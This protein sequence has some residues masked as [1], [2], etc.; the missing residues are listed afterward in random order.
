MIM[1]RGFL[2]FVLPL[3]AICLAWP[4]ASVGLP[5]LPSKDLPSTALSPTLQVKTPA[6]G[7]NWALGSKH[8]ITWTS[9]NVNGYLRIDLFR[10]LPSPHKVGTITGNVAVSNGKYTWD[11]GKYLGGA[12]TEHGKNY[13]IV[14]TTDNPSLT[15]S[16]PL[17]NLTTA[18]SQLNPPLLTGIKKLTLTYPRRGDAFHKGMRYTITWQSVNLNNTRLKLEL[19]DNDEV[20]LRQTIANNFENK[21]KMD[22]DVPKL[23]NKEGFYKIKLQTMDGAQK[24]I[25]GP[26][27]IS[28]GTALPPSLKV[29]NPI[30]GD[31]SFGDTIPV[32][33]TSTAACSGSGGPRDAAFKIELIKY[34]DRD[35][36]IAQDMLTD[37]GFSFDNENPS[38][39]LNWH[40]DWVVEPNS[41][42]PGTYKIKVTSLISQKA[43]NDESDKFRITYA[44]QR[45]TI[46]LIGKR[47][48]CVLLH[49]CENC[50][51]DPD[52]MNL[53]SHDMAGIGDYPLVGYNFY[54]NEHPTNSDSTSFESLPREIRW[55]TVRSSVT[56]G[57]DPYWYKKIGPIQEAK[58]ILKR[59]WKTAYATTKSPAL[60]G[61]S[62]ETQ[63]S[64]C[65]NETLRGKIP[66]NTSQ[67]DSWEVNVTAHYLALTNKGKPD[68]GVIL[69][70][71][72]D[73]STTCND[74]CMRRNA[75]NYEVILKVRVMEKKP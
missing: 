58:L 39:Y 67:G 69:Y 1:K 40:W 27:K 26:I 74:K 32:K 66:V 34:D 61:V 75:E 2:F 7:E 23:P 29:T 10:D 13:R 47:K 51:H 59:K 30:T 8:D 14:L 11:A 43:C 71:K 65:Q 3:F 36:I 49:R 55:F 28:S 5:K 25:V 60:G 33:W 73:Y 68:Y 4:S 72:A 41:C 18:S 9:S 57:D 54:Y 48:I 15:K 22:W 50:S 37:K 6:A 45:K 35:K 62:M 64:G 53:Q 24:S 31:K 56:F 70:P 38:G 52:H 63:A 44:Q 46:E 20:T 21:G 12:V 17:F 16:S 42:Q 19:F